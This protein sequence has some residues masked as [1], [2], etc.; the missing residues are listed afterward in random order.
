MVGGNI[1]GGDG[2]TDGDTEGHLRHR[3]R[4]GRRITA[5]G[6]IVHCDGQGGVTTQRNCSKRGLEG[7]KGKNEGRSR[8]CED[9]RKK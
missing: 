6:K 9:S 5:D 8:G 2:Q 3:R 7:L 4:K 1:K